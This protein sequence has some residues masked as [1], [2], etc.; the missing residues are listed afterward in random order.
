MAPY[1]PETATPEEL[2]LRF[3]ALSSPADVAELLGIEL[4]K[5]N[6]LIYRNKDA[7][8]RT[9]QV[10]KRRGGFRE[11][12]APIT[13]LK[14]I[15]RRLLQVLTAVY[16][17]RR[18]VH[19]FVCGRGIVSNAA[20][21]KG[22]CWVL[23]VDLENF[24]PAINF[25]R[26]RGLFAARPYNLPL[27][28]ATVLA[29]ICCHRKHL[30]QGAPTSPIVSN[31]LCAG[32]DTDLM[33]LARR[34][35]CT[36][37]RYADDITIST[38]FE[39]FPPQLASAVPGMGV[40]LGPALQGLLRRAGFQANDRKMRLQSRA[41]RQEVTGLVTNKIVNVPRP[42]IRQIRGMIHAWREH[43]APAA[44]AEFRLKYA[45][46]K[47]RHPDKGLPDLP[48][49]LLGKLEHL[50]QV[51]G[52]DNEMYRRLVEG[53]RA[54]AQE[55]LR[56][57]VPTDA[58]W[59][60]KDDRVRYQGTAFNLVG[61]GIVTCWHAL[62]NSSKLTRDDLVAGEYGVELVRGNKMYDLALLKAKA[63]V[64]HELPRGK[65]SNLQRGDPLTIIGFPNWSQGHSP[66]ILHT[67]VTGWV[68]RF[69][70][71]RIMVAHPILG[72]MSGGPAL[73]K[74]GEVV[75]VAIL[76]AAPVR[77][78]PSAGNQVQLIDLCDDLLGLSET[79]CTWVYDGESAFAPR[80]SADAT[81]GST[82][83]SSNKQ[84]SAGTQR[85]E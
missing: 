49:V 27:N 36:V 60:L 4:S 82:S 79:E 44:T 66:Q 1:S 40:Q 18:N 70:T 83:T 8:Y 81:S 37:T 80:W 58:V 38:S 67:T 59:A 24:F 42:F 84:T 45:H 57:P 14:T 74:A 32:M 20:P 43:G 68:T 11:V 9:F 51:R 85:T 50:R 71:R 48:S 5:L 22:Q 25:G 62:A 23:N 12:A 26:V 30:P 16:R 6:F 15:Q 65:P 41:T 39:N 47:H 7:A 72:G 64:R 56:L 76:G 35:R 29:Q 78:G 61:L 31:M 77:G 2:R 34:Y 10:R 3:A 21:H 19:G 46:L 13:A 55:F 28:V 52:T 33:K 53:G 54:F 63:P 73:N 17:P 75:G 69:Q